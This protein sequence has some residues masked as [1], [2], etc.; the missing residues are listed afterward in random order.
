[1]HHRCGGGCYHGDVRPVPSRSSR[2]SHA[3]VLAAFASATLVL[4]AACSSPSTREAP[5]TAPAEAVDLGDGG[6]GGDAVGTGG[7]G[8][9]DTRDPDRTDDTRDTG[10]GARGGDGLAGGAPA[11]SG[12]GS[13]W[14]EVEG[15]LTFRGNPTRT[16]YGRGPVPEAPEELWRFPDRPMC[17]ESSVG[18]ESRT[19][20]GT[21]WTG[22]P[23]VWE[24]GG[25]TRVAFGAY[26]RAVHVLEAASGER[27]LPDFVTG[28]IVKGSV[29]V[30]PDGFP[31]L[32]S[33]SR[34]GNFRLLGL[35][36]PEPVELFRLAADAV[37]P[38]MWN[39]DWDGSALVVDDRLLVG[40]E[41]S[42]VHV[43][44][45]H[46]RYG[47][48]GLVRVSP[49][50]VW[51]AP[52]WDEELLDAVGD[53]QMSI[54]GSVA[55]AGD[56]LYFANSG[57]LVQGWDL[58]GLEEGSEPRRVF[59]YWVGDD[60]DASV[61]VDEEGMLY[62]GVEWERHTDRAAELGQVLKLDPSADDPLVWAQTDRAAEK[63]GVWG[64]PALHRDLVIATTHTGRLLG[65]DRDS[66]E[67]RWE[68]RLPGP[69]WQSPV[70]VDDVLVQGDCAGVLHGFDV[71]DTTV[72]P[73]E[74]WSVTLSGCIEST[75]AVWEGRIYVGTR[76]G[77]LH[78]LADSSDAPSG[79]EEDDRR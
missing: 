48:D 37:S 72:E 6:G 26:D 21:G 65:I 54:E 45:L 64:T 73:P 10:D 36:R 70:V 40:G 77:F 27:V 4:A 69:L 29:T 5:S 57:G 42:Q 23:A 49:E 76:G 14:G 68:R 1:M 47:S 66:G 7:S 28:D 31:I 63:A 30:D 71:S 39:D 75:P 43:L 41:N 60:V 61:V 52:G 8:D 24:S 20:C 3:S 2:A 34:D 79:V 33:G 25:G 16:F 56:V 18:G 38:T 32:Y 50:L 58:A 35:D 22:Q 13:P 44:R 12:V 53:R 62:V 9:G 46:R 55:L 11:V 74:L 19:W 17:S 67:L 59:R 78:A 15:L 51:H